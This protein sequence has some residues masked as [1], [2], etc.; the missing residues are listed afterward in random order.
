MV[1]VGLTV[2]VNPVEPSFQTTVPEQLETVN[3]ADCPAQMLGLL[4]VGAGAGVTVTVLMVDPE[5]APTVH[6]AE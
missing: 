3:T 5:Q 2:L 4:T 6:V 1:V